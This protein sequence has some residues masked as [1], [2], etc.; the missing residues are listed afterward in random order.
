MAA[1]GPLRSA[2][3]GDIALSFSLASLL[4]MLPVMAMGLAMFFGLGVSQRIGEQRTVVLSLLIIGV[5]TVSRLFLDSAAELVLSAVP[6]CIWIALN[7][8]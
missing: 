7:P 5:A 4:T 1:V 8:D 6:A 3:R 2:I